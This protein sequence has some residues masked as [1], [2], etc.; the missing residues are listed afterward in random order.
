MK[1]AK[2]FLKKNK[3]KL[4]RGYISLRYRELSKK[5]EELHKMPLFKECEEAWEE[6]LYDWLYPYEYWIENDEWEK[7]VAGETFTA[8]PGDEFEVENRSGKKVRY[9][10]VMA[11][12]YTCVGGFKTAVYESLKDIDKE[13]VFI[14]GDEDVF[15]G[16]ERKDPYFKP[17]YSPELLEQSCYVGGAVLIRKDILQKALESRPGKKSGS[18]TEEKDEAPADRKL[19]K[20]KLRKNEFY[21]L[22]KEVS[23]SAEEAVFNEDEI[24]THLYKNVLH[25]PHIICHSKK[26]IAAS[27]WEKQDYADYGNG[28]DYREAS[29]AVSGEG[30]YEAS[31]DIIIPTKDHPDVLE[32][33]I[34][35]IK[36]KSSYGKFSI[37]VIDNGSSEGAKLQ[38]QKLSREY[39]FDYIY[40]PQ[41]FNY[42]RINNIAIRK[43]NSDLVLL[44]NDDTE[45]ITGSFLE[46]MAAYALNPEVGAVG[47]KLLFAN[48]NKIQHVGV[49]NL[50]VGPSHKLLEADDEKDHYFGAN[51][52]DRNVFSVTGACMMIERRKLE[53][54]GLLNEDLAVAYNDIDLCMRLYEAGFR[55]VQCN[56]AVLYHYESLTRGADEG[57]GDKWKR[58]LEEKEKLYSYHPWAK[59]FDPFYNPNLIDNSADY[60]PAAKD[61]TRDTDAFCELLE[62]PESLPTDSLMI[63]A[64]LDRAQSQR[65][66]TSEGKD[67]IWMDGW[68]FARG[69]DNRRFDKSLCFT[70]EDKKEILRYELFATYRKDIIR[71]FPGED[72]IDLS[73]FYL[74]I[75]A[76][77]L[78]DHEWHV[79]IMMTDIMSGKML[80]RDLK[81]VV[82]NG[83]IVSR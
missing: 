29:P 80:C 58:L 32:T 40:D 76:D 19:K 83:M 69:C 41:P 53:K 18:G 67:F 51:R 3:E 48:S 47:A 81:T 22:I 33:C 59:G 27:E 31:I 62:K 55:S 65:R 36:E 73:G 54:A 1:N 74:R 37:T 14:Y 35:S 66:N 26:K 77:D 21:D 23:K 20:E 10:L 4:I 44:L 5:G 24:K 49:T 17:D 46:K 68:G 34:D 79:S 28:G 12:D 61:C 2:A 78:G 64:R 56:S 8:S 13:P 45:V 16:F 72:H 39:G 63:K 50:A 15:D 43:T 82:K 42:S 52:L 7:R 57:S 71:A 30:K 25:I 70:R 60:L 9:I 11:E 6:E 75:P 38:N